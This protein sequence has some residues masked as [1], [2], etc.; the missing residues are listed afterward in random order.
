MNNYPAI[1]QLLQKEFDA[2][3]PFFNS[4]GG[5]IKVISTP[6]WQT[7]MEHNPGFQWIEI[8]APKEKD[9]SICF[10]IYDPVMKTTISKENIV[11]EF[12]NRS[13]TPLYFR[14]EVDQR[15]VEKPDFFA[16]IKTLLEERS[17]KTDISAYITKFSKKVYEMK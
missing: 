17:G 5:S 1:C 16:F 6:G 14:G 2:L 9:Q 8:R 15:D 12:F 13:L 10:K 11:I 7:K 3:Q 4:G